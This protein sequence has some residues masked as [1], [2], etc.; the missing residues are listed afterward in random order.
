[1]TT[2]DDRFDAV[3]VGAGQAGLAMGYEL[4]R[5]AQRFVI[6]DG[7]SE[8]GASWR[9]RWDSLLLFT[10]AQYDSLPGMRFPAPPDTYPTKDQVADYLYAYAERF[11]LPVALGRRVTAV[12]RRDEGFLLETSAGD[13]HAANVIVATGPFQ[14]PW[15]PPA[16]EEAG[17]SIVQLHSAG[18][19]NPAALPPGRALVV[20]AANSGCQIARELSATHRVEL[21]VGSRQPALPQ[22]LL[23]K[24]IWWWGETLGVRRVTI[25]SRLGKRLS[26]RDPVIGM[27]PRRLGARFGIRLRSRVVGIDGAEVRFADGATSRPDT[28]VWA[29]GYRDDF[30][31]IGVPGVLDADGHPVHRRGVSSVPGMFFVGLGWLWTRGSGLIGWV[32]EDAAY[33]ADRI[34]S[35]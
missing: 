10:P 33:L 5:R 1:V 25:E 15:L 22:R 6:V 29:T 28:I 35:T 13:L 30:T 18:Y 34:A 4:A 32:G 26:L 14:R 16:S 20:G 19:R 12:S 11:A 3:V 24:D 2:P 9:S 21:A 17:E 31:W 7:A 8:L 27:G 23:G